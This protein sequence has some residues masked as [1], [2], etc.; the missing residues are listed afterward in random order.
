MELAVGA[1]LASSGKFGGCGKVL[2]IE[3]AETF[4]VENLQFWIKKRPFGV[5]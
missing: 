1:R 4:R 3:W 5:Y 2:Q